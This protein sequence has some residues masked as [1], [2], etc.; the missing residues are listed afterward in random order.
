MYNTRPKFCPPEKNLRFY[1]WKLLKI[2]FEMR[3]LT[4]RCPQSGHFCPKLGHF[5]PILELG[6]GRS[7]ACNFMKKE[8]WHRCFPVHFEKIL[9]TP[10][11]QNTS[12][13]LLLPIQYFKAYLSVSMI[14][15]QL[16]LI[17]DQRS[18]AIDQWSVAIA[19]INVNDQLPWQ[20]KKEI[21]KN[22]SVNPYNTRGD[23]LLF[24][25]RFNATH[26]G[27]KSLRYNGPLTWSNFS[28]SMNNNF[29]K[30]CTNADLNISL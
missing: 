3:N 22:E 9:G 10:F 28:Q 20:V 5:F 16:P 15:D 7:Q 11:L 1:S 17:N 6:Q 27:T 12:W 24:I 13:R 18:V 30:R 2:A 26:F 14:N 19:M 4:H 21:I 8:T 29:F 25:S 23:K